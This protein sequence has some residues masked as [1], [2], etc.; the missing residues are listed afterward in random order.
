M[1]NKNKFRNALKAIHTTFIEARMYAYHNDSYYKINFQINLSIKLI[2]LFLD[3]KDQTNK[4]RDYCII[5][6]EKY[7]NYHAIYEFNRECSKLSYLTNSKL[8][9]KLLLELQNLAIKVNNMVKEEKSYSYIAN[10]LDDIEYLVVLM[11]HEKDQTENFYKYL[12]SMLN[13]PKRTKKMIENNKKK[14]IKMLL[15]INFSPKAISETSKLS[16]SEIEKIIKENN[17]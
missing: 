1:I 3:S 6:S 16:I 15:D 9:N 10:F 4:F 14:L 8:T 12:D 17:L 2:E 7:D 11:M 13:P 5:F